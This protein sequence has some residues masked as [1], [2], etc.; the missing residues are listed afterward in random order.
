MT[1][2]RWSE[3]SLPFLLL[4]SFAIGVGIALFSLAFLRASVVRERG[5]DLARTAVGAADT[6][7]RILFRRVVDIRTFAESHHD[8]DLG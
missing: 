7:D 3:L 1:S 4:S 2:S 8:R 6:I 5:E